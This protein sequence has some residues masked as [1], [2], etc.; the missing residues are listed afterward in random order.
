[1]LLLTYT[2]E[3]WELPPDTQLWKVEDDKVRSPP[4][5]AQSPH[6]GEIYLIAGSLLAYLVPEWGV[7]NHVG[8]IPSLRP[9]ENLLGGPNFL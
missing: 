3:T 2:C 9:A 8:N 4:S 7:S 6:D 1:M 5:P